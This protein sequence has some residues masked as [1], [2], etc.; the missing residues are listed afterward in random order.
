MSVLAAVDTWRLRA[1]MKQLR[2]S[3]AKRAL[4]AGLVK[5][6]QRGAKHIK[7]SIPGKYKSV[8]KA[9]GWRSLKRKDNNGEPGVKIGAAVGKAASK[10]AKTSKDRKGRSGV[11]ID[12]RNVH[13]WFLGTDKRYTGT[14]RKR[15]GG[16][17]G[18]GGWKGVAVRSRT[19]KAVAYRGAMPPQARPVSV[20]LRE[21][22][23]ELQ[24]IIRTWTWVGVKKEVAK[25]RA[26]S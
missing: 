25:E 6:A 23:G 5:A 9:I 26:R 2:V 22:E 4:S 1:A 14:K 19:G 20:M 3:G 21:V 8:R 16:R 17:R 13:W 18:R 15:I 10:A 24:K 7:A 12:A 11:G